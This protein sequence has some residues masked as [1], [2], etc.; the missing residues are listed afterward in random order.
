MPNQPDYN[1]LMA[2]AAKNVRTFQIWGP[3]ANVTF[4]S[5]S[6][7]FAAA[8]QNKTP[9]SAALDVMQSATVTDMK[10]LGFKVAG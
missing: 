1:T 6:N 9:L 8:L 4:D 5:Y 2:T 10:K 7:A 3:D